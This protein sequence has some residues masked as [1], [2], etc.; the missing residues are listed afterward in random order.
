MWRGGADTNVCVEGGGGLQIQMCVW[1]GVYIYRG[2]GGGELH[3]H[4]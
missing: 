1:V 2:K 3:A 4:S